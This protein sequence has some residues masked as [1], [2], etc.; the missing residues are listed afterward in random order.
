MDNHHLL[1]VDQLFTK[2]ITGG[3]MLYA[4]VVESHNNR[5]YVT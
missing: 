2:G 5:R 4:V 1:V 3:F